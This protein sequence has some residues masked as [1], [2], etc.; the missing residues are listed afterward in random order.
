M[1]PSSQERLSPLAKQPM[2]VH[3]LPQHFSCPEIR[4]VHFLP[5]FVPSPR[6][7]PSLPELPR[8]SPWKTAESRRARLQAGS[9]HQ[10][11]ASWKS[12]CQGNPRH[13]TPCHPSEGGHLPER[14]ASIPCSSLNAIDRE[15]NPDGFV[16]WTVINPT[17]WTPHPSRFCINHIVPALPRARRTCRGAAGGLGA[18]SHVLMKSPL[19]LLGLLLLRQWG[20]TLHTESPGNAQSPDGQVTDQT[21]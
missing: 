14:T 11:E 5:L 10:C 3:Q 17:S 21:N 20:S 4:Q 6:I 16:I 9:E 2:L 15:L 19:G 7:C 18:H 8:S 12:H 13:M 1:L